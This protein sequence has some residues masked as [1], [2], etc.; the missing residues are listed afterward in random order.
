M[1]RTQLD[2]RAERVRLGG[3]DTLI[4]TVAPRRVT[5]FSAECHAAWRWCR[6]PGNPIVGNVSATAPDGTRIVYEVP[7]TETSNGLSR[8]LRGR[9]LSCRGPCAVERAPVPV[10]RGMV[11][12]LRSPVRA[13]R[14]RGIAAF[15]HGACEGCECAQPLRSTLRHPRA[16]VVG[17]SVRLARRSFSRSHDAY[18]WAAKDIARKATYLGNRAPREWSAQ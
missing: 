17:L 2:L 9:H 4:A 15:A 6:R 3:L 7:R 12:R 16:V 10:I 18:V 13:A 1:F 8:R 14:H 11:S 5:P